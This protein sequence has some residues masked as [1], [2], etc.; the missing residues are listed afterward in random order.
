GFD[1]SKSTALQTD[2]AKQGIL[3]A[4]MAVPA[5]LLVLCALSLKF[6]PLAGKEWDEIK[7]AIEEKHKDKTE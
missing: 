4:W 3:V 7:T 1:M 6:Y 2:W 5:I